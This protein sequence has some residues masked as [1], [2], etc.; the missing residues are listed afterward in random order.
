MGMVLTKTISPRVTGITETAIIEP[1]SLTVTHIIDLDIDKMITKILDQQQRHQ[2][3]NSIVFT[4][5]RMNPPTKGHSLLI[6]HVANLAKTANSDHMV[7]LSQSFG[8][9]KNPLEWSFKL[10]VCREAFPDVKFSD[11]ML[12]LNPYHAL[13]QLIAEDYTS[14]IFVVGSDRAEEFDTMYDYANLFGVDFSVVSCATRDNST[15]VHGISS[16]YLRAQ[17]EIDNDSEFRKWLPDGIKKVTQQR[18]L[19]QVKKAVKA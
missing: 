19:E 9:R 13:E 4:F 17:A 6:N 18:I 3:S 10:S 16:S 5:G 2:K 1:D 7:F 15:G 8:N 11:N 14:I 12:I